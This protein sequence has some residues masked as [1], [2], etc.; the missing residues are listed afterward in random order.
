VELTTRLA[1]TKVSLRKDSKMSM[2]IIKNIQGVLLSASLILSL[3]LTAQ[4]T[5]RIRFNQIGFQPGMP[6]IA[7][8]TGST[9]EERFYVLAANGKDTVFRGRLSAERK[10]EYSSTVTRLAD[11]S[12]MKK[13]GKFMLYV[14][15]VGR[16]KE[17]LVLR[18]VYV[19]NEIAINWNAAAVYLFSAMDALG[20]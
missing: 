14:P 16:S 6:K 11:F 18:A 12:R 15:G 8:V 20:R 17:F 19:S 5:D 3:N 1:G 10:S 4:E 2:D 9:P 7:V 13:R